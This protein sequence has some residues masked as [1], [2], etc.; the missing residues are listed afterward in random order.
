M[1]PKKS[2]SASNPG[3]R[4]SDPRL[5]PVMKLAGQDMRSAPTPAEHVLWQRLR[6]RELGTRFRRQHTI[7]RFIVDFVCLTARVVIEVDG[8]I[9]DEP[10]AR[11]RDA[12]RA[13]YLEAAGFK[14]MRFTNAQVLEELDSVVAEIQRHVTP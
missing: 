7:G 3:F 11:S 13:D 1:A 4:T 12:G 14:T 2:P 10:D 9:H 5:W 8:P 6:R